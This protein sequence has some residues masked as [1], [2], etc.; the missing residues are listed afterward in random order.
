MKLL[1]ATLAT[2]LLS[3]SAAAEDLDLGKL[4][5]DAG[6]VSTDGKFNSQ[7]DELHVSFSPI[8]RNAKGEVEHVGEPEIRRHLLGY[9]SINTTTFRDLD[10]PSGE[11][12]LSQV[13]YRADYQ[14][15]CLLEKT[16]LVEVKAGETRY[17]GQ[18]QFNEPSGS[19]QLDASSYVPIYGVSFDLEDAYKSRHWRYGEAERA[20]L[21]QISVAADVGACGSPSLDVQA[22]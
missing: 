7:I 22:W 10:L 16:L 2:A 14:A 5:W 3:T 12:I 11:Y 18:L 19:P 21:Q 1:T 4:V 8:Q 15:F 20:A 6:I 9:G 13:A 17:L